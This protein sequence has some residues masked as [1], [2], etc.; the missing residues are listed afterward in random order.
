[1]NHHNS[2]SSLNAHAVSEG[3]QLVYGVMN[4]SAAEHVCKCQFATALT[5]TLHFDS[6]C[7]L[8]KAI[9]FNFI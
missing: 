1:M 8:F 9:I 7:L 5:N 6:I 3:L 2:S 4:L